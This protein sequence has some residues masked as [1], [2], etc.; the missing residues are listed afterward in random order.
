MADPELPVP[1]GLVLRPFRGVRF[2]VADLAAV[3]S[4]PYDLIGETGVRDLLTAHPNNVVRLILPGA[5]RHRYAEARQTLHAWLSSSVLVTDEVPGVYVYEQSGPGTLQR[6]LIGEVGLA[7]PERGTILPHEDV[8][9]G[10]VADR[11]ALMRTTEANLEPIFLLYEG[12]GGAATRLVDQVAAARTP[13][14]E[15]VTG[16]GLRHRLWAVTDP[17]ELAAVDADLR[18]R[19]ALIADGHHRYATYRALQAEHRATGHE[20]AGHHTAASPDSAAG[21]WDFGLALLV[22]SDAYPPDLQAIH[23]VIPGLPLGEALARAKGAWQAH[24]YADLAEGLA[25]LREIAGPAF[26]LA[27]GGPAHLITDPDPDQV[28]HAMPTGRSARWRALNTSILAEFL[29][30]KVWG[31]R[32]DEHSVRIVHHDPEAAVRLA[33]DFGGT[34]VLMNP[35]AVDDVLAVAA[36]GERVPRKSTSFGPKPRT[37]LLMRLLTPG[38]SC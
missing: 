5:D 22:D 25:A 24:E 16:D 13:L 33:H 7:S 6:G 19:R 23:R 9:P 26:L 37:G 8:M 27:A 15:T 14:V 2:A 32:D 36:Q 30:P 31:M 29:L 20:A 34:A 38:R 10:P 4:P 18:P 1:D 28:A 17:A 3:T 11:L 21:P 35:L 12:G